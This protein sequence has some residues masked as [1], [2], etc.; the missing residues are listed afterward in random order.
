MGVNRG[1]LS[2]IGLE[3]AVSLDGLSELTS[4]YLAENELTSLKIANCPK[5]TAVN[6]MGN[7]LDELE[8]TNCDAVNDL[9]AYYNYLPQEK[10]D[11]LTLQYASE[12]SILEL[13]PQY[14]K[15]DSDQFDSQEVT[16]LLDFVSQEDNEIGLYLD[17]EAPG[18]WEQVTWEKQ[19]DG[20]YHITDLDLGETLVLGELDLSRMH[21]LKSFDLHDTGISKVELPEELKEIPAKAFYGCDLLESVTVPENVKRIDDLTF[22]ECSNLKNLEML[23]SNAELGLNLTYHS[24]QLAK[25]KC[26]PETT[27]AEYSY[28]EQVKIISWY[29]ADEDGSCRGCSETIW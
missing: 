24:E 15:G 26:Y 11:E 22:A 7:Q 10:V 14:V 17:P 23:C 21:Y 5:L 19:E 2:G 4:V 12:D 27:E 1:N 29:D 28:G 20:L 9:L 16:A 8:L 25:V 13:L 3:K 6:C 18:T